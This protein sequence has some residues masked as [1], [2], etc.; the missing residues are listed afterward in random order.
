MKNLANIEEVGR[1]IAVAFV[2]T[3]YGVGIANIFLFPPPT[4]SKLVRTR[5]RR[6]RELMLE[7][8]LS[9]AEGLNQKL[10]RLKLEAYSGDQPA[11]RRRQEIASGAKRRRAA[12]PPP[13]AEQCR[14]LKPW[15]GKD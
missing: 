14:G 11:D 7:G 3:I 8:V 1:G 2:A 6:T 15:R 5:R 9:I 12:R 13:R 10:I 4:S